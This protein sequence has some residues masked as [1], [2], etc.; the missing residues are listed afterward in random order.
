MR[1]YR[2]PMILSTVGALCGYLLLH[3]YTMLV[4]TLIHLHRE[5]GLHFHWKDLPSRTL[6]AFDPMMLPMAVSFALFGGVIGLLAGILIDRRR[7]L[8]AAEHEN[9]EKRIA[10]ETLREVMVTLSHY[11]LNA[12]MII[13]GKVRHCRKVTA[14]QDILAALAVIEEQGRKIDA[15]ISA[16]RDST[17]IKVAGYAGDGAVKMMDISREIE[18]R[19]GRAKESAS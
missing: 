2:L 10:L 6:S 14:D 7:R 13:G 1:R 15:V 18:E 17:E 11:L 4:Y 3:P 12:N 9:K 16:L 5:N 8:T 19:I